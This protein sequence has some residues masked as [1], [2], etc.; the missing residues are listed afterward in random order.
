MNVRGRITWK[1]AAMKIIAQHLFVAPLNILKGKKQNMSS[2]DIHAMK[3]SHPH[4]KFIR[5]L[6]LGVLFLVLIMYEPKVFSQD[7]HNVRGTSI[8]EKDIDRFEGESTQRFFSKILEAEVYFNS[9][10]YDSSLYA[11]NSA[12]DVYVHFPMEIDNP[13]FF[14]LKDKSYRQARINYL[15]LLEIKPE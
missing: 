14:E 2:R 11:F 12:R 4:L 10:H 1:M 7:D 6:K 3:N 8:T 9:Q 13:Y 5:H 15:K